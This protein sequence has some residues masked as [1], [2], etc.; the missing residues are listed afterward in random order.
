MS[1]FHFKRFSISH[2]KS[3]I[4]VGTDAV[5]L[6][7][8]A[9]VE[10]VRR[11]LDVGTGCG[12]VALMLLQRGVQEA[13]A[14]EIDPDAAQ[15]AQENAKNSDWDT[16]IKV[17]CCDF[18]DKKKI[19]ELGMFDLVIS[20]PPFFSHSLSSPDQKRNRARHNDVLPFPI[21]LEHVAAVLDEEG[22]FCVI[23][24]SS[25]SLSFITLAQMNQLYLA[26]RY[27]IHSK[28]NTPPIRDILLFQK[29]AIIPLKRY[30]LTIYNANS[31]YTEEFVAL[32]KD[33]YQNL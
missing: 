20:N 10:G 32:T 12:V 19:S 15:E 25:E 1:V 13:V 24:P 28:P 9:P 3:G 6:G 31:A 7:A 16:Q 2:E 17:L 23:L 11:V 30:T 27:A 26:E 8:V 33:F 21:L 5:L 18:C 29:N 14:V 4:K 22:R